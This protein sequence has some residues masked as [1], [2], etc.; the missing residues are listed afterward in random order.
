MFINIIPLKQRAISAHGEVID[1]RLIVSRLVIHE[2]K[3]L[4][5]NCVSKV[6]FNVIKSPNNPIVLGQ[7]WLEFHNLGVDWQEK[8]LSS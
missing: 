1:G 2:A 5:D 6:A 7:N 4:V 3:P 8:N